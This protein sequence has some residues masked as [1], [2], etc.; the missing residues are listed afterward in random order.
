M[1]GRRS[2]PKFGLKRQ[3]G[4]TNEG[5]APSTTRGRDKTSNTRLLCATSAPALPKFLFAYGLKI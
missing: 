1:V 3:T 2:V 5:G 4:G